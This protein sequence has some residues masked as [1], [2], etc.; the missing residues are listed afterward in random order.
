M[1]KNITFGNVSSKIANDK[2]LPN[3]L[4]LVFHP[5]LMPIAGTLLILFYSGLYIT[6]LPARAKEIILLIVGVC[7][8]LLPVLLLLFYR[9]HQRVSDLRVSERRE[10][11][12]PLISTAVFYF[13]A[14]RVLHDLHTPYIIQKFV[15][16]SAVAVF[17]T[18]IISLS[19]KIS[20]HGVGIGGITGMSAALSVVSA[21]LLPCML[22][23]IILSGIIGY[24]RIKLNAHTP[25][26]YYAGVLLGFSVM[27][28]MFFLF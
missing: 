1:R 2:A 16:A 19:W 26:Q 10:R 20:L 7:T 27:F 9:I 8:L 22:V 28:G 13:M 25:A 6:M 12:M 21:A 15:L 11:I 14:Y 17:L 23:A 4:S 5:V 24:A 18:S 3:A